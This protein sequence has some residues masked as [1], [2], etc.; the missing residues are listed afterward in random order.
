MNLLHISTFLQGGAGK[1]IADLAVKEKSRGNNI[2]VVC[3]KKSTGNY[4]N[5]SAHLDL[6]H[7]KSIPVIFLESTFKRELNN[8]TSASNQ[9]VDIITKYEVDLIHSH[10]GTPSLIAMIAA[11]KAS[12]R[13]PVL[14]TMHGWGIFK[15]KLQ[16]NQDISILN[17]LDRV[18]TVSKS[19]EKVLVKNGLKHANHSTIY[20]GVS[21]TQ[22]L[23]PVEDDP[24][25]KKVKRLK[26]K[27]HFIGGCVGTIDE[28]KNQRLI[29]EALNILP[30]SLPYQFFFIGEGTAIQELKILCA[31]YGISD[32]VHFLDWGPNGREYISL[33]DL[34]VCPSLSE[35]APPLTMME[36][37]A[38]KVPVLASNTSEHSEAIKH[39]TTGL[40]FTNESATSLAKLL[41]SC[42]NDGEKNQYAANAYQYFE[43]NFIFEKNSNKYNKLYQRLLENLH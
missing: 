4:S 18:V 19:S 41:E 31:E 13:I 17:L 1:V 24:G 35:G 11:T 38:E 27:G 14:Q 23:I 12:K 8:I 16:K 2:W 34:L 3:T 20:N 30:V 33:L 43:E 25:I 28:R 9:L 32:K 40:L 15:T 42:I 37:F 22:K 5:Y 10:A 6:L 39:K 21:S 29:I 7:E 36:A 26:S